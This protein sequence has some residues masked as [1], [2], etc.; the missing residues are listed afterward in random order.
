MNYCYT[1]KVIKADSC[2][3]IGGGNIVRP[4]LVI[5]D[6]DGL[7]FDT[8]RVYYEAW[9]QAAKFYGYEFNWDI[10]IQLVA[11]NS[12]TIGMILRKIY[13][14]DFPY[15]E[16]SQKKRELAD[17][18]L[19]KQGITKKA[20]LMELLDF[21]EAEGISKAVATSSTREKA[22][23]YLSLGGVK[24]RFDHIV[25]GSDVVESK[26]NPE[27]FQVA[28]QALQ[29]IP[30]KCMVLEDSK[31]GIKAAKAAGMY[32]VLIPDLVKADDEM[33]ED[34]SFIVS[35]LHEVINLIKS[36][37]QVVK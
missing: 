37:K 16:A 27:I 4:E 13:G 20:G 3:K 34:A 8:E 35:S 7:M 32:G 9:E 26:P 1:N 2:R 30:E 5:F 21:L 12:R 11:R 28:A 36:E 33:R 25:C 24:E 19:E 15:E 6:M 18:I 17:Q 31:M 23:A 22:L 29:K 10:Y 14:E